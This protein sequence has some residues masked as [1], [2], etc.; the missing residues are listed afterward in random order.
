MAERYVPRITEAA[1]PE[2]GSWAELTGKNVLMLHVPE[3]EEEVRL[4]FRG[5]QRVWLYDRREDAYIF[6]FRLKDGT[7]RALAF[8][9]DHG[10]RLLMDERA[11]GFFS[12]LIVTE[13]LDSLQKETPMLLFPEVFLKRHPKAG[14]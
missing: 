5:A 4:P 7:E 12:I 6:C 3:W 1:I 11:Y 13:E 2:D 10:G 8:A 9:K 14:W